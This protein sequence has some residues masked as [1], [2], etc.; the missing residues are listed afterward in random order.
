MKRS[1]NVLT[2][3]T[4]KFVTNKINQGNCDITVSYGTYI[5]QQTNVPFN[6]RY[7]EA[8]KMKTLIRI[9]KVKDK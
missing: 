1:I 7:E 3:F 6:E 9:M 5:L 4:T 2:S 8:E